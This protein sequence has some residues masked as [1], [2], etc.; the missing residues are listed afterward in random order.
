MVFSWDKYRDKSVIWLMHTFHVQILCARSPGVSKEWQR[1]L[2][3][4]EGHRGS[5]ICF[6]VC[7]D[8]S[9][10]VHLLE[11]LERVRSYVAHDCVVRAQEKSCAHVAYWEQNRG[12]NVAATSVQ[13]K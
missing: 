11:K 7:H 3:A 10:V 12:T 4:R 13:I 1:R 6:M 8:V 2:E 9:W 5:V